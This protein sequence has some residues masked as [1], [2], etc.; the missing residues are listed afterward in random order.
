MSINHQAI[1]KVLKQNLGEW[2]LTREVRQAAIDHAPKDSEGLT[3]FERNPTSTAG[4][5]RRLLNILTEE[6]SE[7]R[8]RH[9]KEKNKSH[10]RLI[11]K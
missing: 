2:M 8:V 4:D 6:R 11:K 1:L 9:C 3:Y 10:W 7:Y 5:I